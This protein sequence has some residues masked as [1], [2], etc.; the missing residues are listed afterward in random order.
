LQ[1]VVDLLP[2]AFQH[3]ARTTARLRLGDQQWL[4]PG[5]AE[6][7]EVLRQPLA[8][9]DLPT[10]VLEVFTPIRDEEQDPLFLPQ[11][12]TLLQSLADMLGMHFERHSAFE[13][14]RQSERRYRSLIEASALVVWKADAAGQISSIQPVLQAP[15]QAEEAQSLGDGWVHLVHPDDAPQVMADWQ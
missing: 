13:Q 3:P 11:E 10:G 8:W 6:Q 1:Q 15:T 4:S 14:L 9:S 2:T 5:F 7:R 12:A